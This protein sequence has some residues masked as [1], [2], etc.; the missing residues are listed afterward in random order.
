MNQMHDV[1]VFDDGEFL[2]VMFLRNA[3]EVEPPF[4]TDHIFGNV[5]LALLHRM[6]MRVKP[7]LF[8]ELGVGPFFD[9]PVIVNHQNPV[10]VFYRGQAVGDNKTGPSL[11][12]L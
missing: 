11:H 3:L 8:N 1:R 6:Q 5:Y 7:V 4:L 10:R 12:E 9:Y 2:G